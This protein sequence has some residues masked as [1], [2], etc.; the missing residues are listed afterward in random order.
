M[1]FSFLDGNQ[2][3]VG[4]ALDICYRIADAVKERLGLP[5]LDVHLNA[6]TSATRLPLITNGTIDLECGSTTNNFERRNQ[7]AF[8]NTDF[9]TATRYVAKKNAGLRT[10]DDLKGKTVVSTSGTINLRQINEANTARKLGLT[11][12]LRGRPCRGV[13]YGPER[14]G[15]GVRDGRR[16]AGLLGRRREEAGRVRDLR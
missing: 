10:I 13:P 9:L 15:G 1:P 2:K 11:I 6:V 5:K 16:A 4:Y 8:T 3:P 7:A 14:A 12:L